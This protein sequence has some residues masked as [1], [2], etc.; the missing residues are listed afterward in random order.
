MD[1]FFFARFIA[2]QRRTIFVVK[3]VDLFSIRRREREAALS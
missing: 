1:S 3:P 2:G